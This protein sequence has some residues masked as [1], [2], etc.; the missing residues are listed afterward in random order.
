MGIK[1]FFT[2]FRSSFPNRI[3]NFSKVN[4]PNIEIDNFMI[5]LNGVFH[6]SAQKVFEYGNYAKQKS[7]LGNRRKAKV[8]QDKLHRLCYKDICDTIDELVTISKPKKRLIMA[9]DG[10]AP[11]G[12]QNQ[13]RQRR[14][15]GVIENPDSDGFDPNCITPGTKFMHDLSIYIDMHIR[16]NINSGNWDFQVIFSNEKCPGEGE[17]KLIN[18]IRK[19]GKNEDSFCINALDSDLFM[20]SLGTNKPKFY[21]LR[22][23]LYDQQFDYMFVDIGDVSLDLKQMLSWEG[24][25]QDKLIND[26]ILICFLCGNDFLPNMPSISIMENG[27]N[28]IVDFYKKNGKHIVEDSIIDFGSL[29]GFL[30]LIGSSESDMM[31]RKIKH[32]NDY[33][34]DTLLTNPEKFDIHEYQQAYNKRYF[35]RE[36]EYV[37]RD[38]LH[39]CQW[40]LSYYLKGVK[41]W[42]WMYTQNYS[43]FAS[44]IINH[45]DAFKYDQRPDTEPF[46]PIQQLLCV[47]PPKSFH[48]IPKPLDKF[49]TKYPEYYPEKFNINYEGKK[50]KWEGVVELPCMNVDIVKDISLDCLKDEDRARNVPE[51][52][53]IYGIDEFSYDFRCQFGNIRSCSVFSENMDF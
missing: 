39:G 37:V 50:K 4:V 35:S 46:F 38:Y 5:D 31:I 28:T 32:R 23:N 52:A 41:N 24:C 43:P 30:N 15:R 53:K 44:D 45:I 26:F 13:Q 17:H 36:I 48:F 47:L 7:L 18:Y 22:E 40:V 20:L 1:H 16:K 25:V 11:L 2:W 21:L 49:Y 51:I 10:V 14:Y 8:D 19:Y 12:K 33:I 29:K 6:N 3:T 34:E 27:L 42:D 9:I